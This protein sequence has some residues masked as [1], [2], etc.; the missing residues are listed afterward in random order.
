MSKEVRVA[1]AAKTANF[2]M[3]LPLSIEQSGTIYNIEPVLATRQ[4]GARDSQ[5][6]PHE[7]GKA[8][9]RPEGPKCGGE[10]QARHDN[11]YP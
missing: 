1:R 7:H 5:A 4:G 6:F 11:P 9:R 10:G 3:R 8:S 2:F